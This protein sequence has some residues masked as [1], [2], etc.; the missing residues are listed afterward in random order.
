MALE[1]PKGET[2]REV[3]P[4]RRRR[5][6][7]AER[8]NTQALIIAAIPIVV[9]LAVIAIGIWVVQSGRQTNAGAT[10]TVT[11]LPTLKPST[12]VAA[13]KTAEPTAALPTAAIAATVPQQTTEPTPLPTTVPT[14]VPSEPTAT[15]IP[16]DI[17]APGST[18]QVAGTNGRG[19]RMRSG[20]GLDQPTLKVVAEGALVQVLAGPTEADGY[21]WYQ[22]KDDTGAEGWVAGDWLISTK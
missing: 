3:G 6:L 4:A 21:Q 11:H 22:I 1:E 18:A 9:L 12:L 7:R 13:K 20:P 14:E 16:D 17:L 2:V 15:S 5:A 8:Q 19:L 10:I